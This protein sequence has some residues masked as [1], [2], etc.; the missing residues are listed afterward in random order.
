MMQPDRVKPLLGEAAARLRPAGC[1]TPELDARLLL[2]WVTGLS[3][4]DLILEP[5][6]PV[7]DVQVT[8]YRVVIAR[9][10]AREPVS[11]I[12]GER[13]FH[14]RTFRVTP[15]TLDPRPDTE[16]LVEMALALMPKGGRFLEL[17]AGTGAVAITL[18][19]ERPDA[20]GATTDLSAAALTV[21]RENAVRHGVAGRLV[22]LHGSWFAPVAGAFDI[23]VSNPPYIASGD[24]EGLSP[25]VRGFDPRLAL[26]GG[27]DGLDAYRAIAAGAVDHLA[28]GGHVAVEI[29]AGQ[30]PAVT[31]I[32]VAAGFVPAG[33][34]LDLGGH[35]RCLAFQRHEN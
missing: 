11:R 23:I 24:I 29:G 18:L 30:A 34:R 21:A 28:A 26:D 33:Q 6:R 16:T 27:Q 5:D 4:E 7:T 1:D 2:Q 8:R 19:A 10:E 17:G 25:D 22:L 31:A 13:E 35:V 3:R 12:L 14:G 15:D 20:R 9:R 32:F